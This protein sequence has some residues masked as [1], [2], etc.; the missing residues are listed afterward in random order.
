MIILLDT[1]T[2]EARLTLIDGEQIHHV[3][4]QADRQL[5]HGLLA[6]IRDSL[7][8]QNKAWKDLRGI[9]VYQGPGSFTGLRIGVAVCNTLADSLG[10]SIVGATGDVWQQV[11]TDRL[12][13]GE[14]DR[15]VLPEYGRDARITTQRK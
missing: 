12:R 13:A 6:W 5:A 9:A 8:E 11:A 2:P 4:W 3:V 14:N 15:V 7:A 10:I 1:S